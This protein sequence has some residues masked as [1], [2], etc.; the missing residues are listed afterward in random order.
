MASAQT[1]TTLLNKLVNPFL[2]AAIVVGLI[3]VF[4]I[5]ASFLGSAGV[6]MKQDTS[7]VIAATFILF[8]A[9][10][11]AILSLMCDN[12]DR[13]WTRSMISYV[14]VAGIAGLLAWAFSSLSINEAG[15]FRWIYIVLTFGYLLFLAMIGAMRKIVD[16]AQREE[17][18]QP[19]I[20][21]RKRR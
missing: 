14:A 12:M 3:L 7:W 8:F 20:R 4:D 1:Q 21:K 15:T 16:F 11:N 18:N 2:Q 19:K 10:F 6:E 9:M 5:G 13:Y 17:W